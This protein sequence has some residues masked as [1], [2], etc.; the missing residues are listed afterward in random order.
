MSFLGIAFLFALPLAAA[1]LLLHL[2]D[3]RRN[4]PI[5]WG[6]MEFLVA[7]STRQ[8]SARRLKQWTLLL[9]RVLAIA[10]LIFS[11]ARPLIPSGWLGS[12]ERRETIFVIDNSMS[13][14]RSNGDQTLMQAILKRSQ[15]ELERLAPGDRVRVLTT[16]PY[17]IW[18]GSRSTRNSGLRIDPSTINSIAQ[19]FQSITP[20]QGR[21]DLL[22]G[23]MAAVQAEP[24]ATTRGRRIVLLTDNQAAD[25]R[26]G[27][28]EGWNGFRE[29][30]S[31]PVIDTE[32]E[33]IQVT[34]DKL[35]RGNVAVDE[36][37]SRRTRIGVD[38]PITLTATVRNHHG[39]SVAAGRSVDWTIDGGIQHDSF[40][41]P[42][43]PGASQ[44]TSWTHSFDTPGV[45]RIA[46]QIVGDDDLAADD[47]AS[48]VIE[49]VDEV[50]VLIV[51]SESR[52]ADTQQDSFFLRAALGWL[53]EQ[54]TAGRAVYAP[55]VVGSDRISSTD[56]R[57]YHVVIVPNLTQLDRESL[58]SLSQFVSDGGGLWV[59]LGPRTDVD[60]F[61]LQWFAGGSGLSPVALDRIV[62]ESATTS[63]NAETDAE[64]D[65]R[66]AVTINPFGSDHP[67]VAQIADNQQL[68]LGEVAVFERFR[69]LIDESDHQTSV[70]LTLSNGDAIVVEQ[71][72]GKGRVFVSAIPL[73]LQWSDLA[74]SQS[75]VVMARDWIDY[76]SQPRATHFNLQPGDP[77]V[78]HPLADQVGQSDGSVSGMLTNPE[79]ESIELAAD[80]FGD[81]ALRTSRT[82]LPGAY[83]LET[84]LAG[85]V[86]PFEVARDI[87]ESDLSPLK[88][89]EQV[90]LSE[91]VGVKLAAGNS[92]VST[93]TPQDPLWPY[94]LIGLITL[95]TLEL[96]L[97]G[98]LARERFGVS[99]LSAGGSAEDVE[100]AIAETKFP[101]VGKQFQGSSGPVTPANT[102]RSSDEIEVTA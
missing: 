102:D 29:S 76:L 46:A 23:L 57:P 69:F 20:T 17:P 72:L 30:L 1:P 50:P 22:A 66:P 60:E 85:D 81:V 38:E 42:I 89:T 95:I 91:L 52:L 55:T 18:R 26:L 31:K 88:R 87:Q 100:F 45:H 62:T 51:E 49:V 40:V 74:R 67:A 44:E 54:P 94:L 53:D 25:W 83:R 37:R 63:A 70:L 75:F 96:L 97:S 71:L 39:L 48:V 15:T 36:V 68:D 73:R 14:G 93:A 58:K 28:T 7:A 34:G 80:G 19:D 35:S 32:L 6:A 21:S 24:E 9:L 12:S 77:L 56:L 65:T 5:E 8:T 47:V 98:V 2:L 92:A 99:G 16:A 27:D 11:L 61:N 33:I 13:T 3:R 86:I 82:S 90:K 78:Y 101:V 79:N 84:S 59:A 4:V 10:A 64:T 43:E 41:D